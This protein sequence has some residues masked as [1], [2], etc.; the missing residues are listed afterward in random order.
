MIRSQREPVKSG[1][2]SV[3]LRPMSVNDLLSQHFENDRIK[4]SSTSGC[5]LDLR[6]DGCDS[7]TPQAAIQ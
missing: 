6:R 2:L 1:F 3:H 5:L 7:G 4:A